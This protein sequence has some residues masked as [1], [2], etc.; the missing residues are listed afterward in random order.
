MM[1][2][3]TQW[4]DDTGAWVLEL[5]PNVF[6][7]LLIAVAGWYLALYAALLVKRSGTR[8][9]W[10]EA[11]VQY[12]ARTVRVVVVVVFA[13]S[14]LKAAGFP[15][16]S[17]LT[18]VGISGVIIG[19]GVRAQIANYFAGVMMLAARPFKKGDLIEFGPPPQI[20]TVT[21]VCMTYTAL[22]S[23]DNV[24]I[25]VPNAVLWRNRIFNFS[26][27]GQRA[28][29]IPITIPYDVNVD[30]V[31]DIALDVLTRHDAV[32]ADPAPSFKVS[33]VTADNVR[34]L[35]VAWSRVESMNVFGDVITQMRGEFAVAGLAVVVPGKDIDL[36]R[37]E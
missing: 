35:L 5:L 14:A 2:V 17:I 10:D 9:K 6:R 25:V 11:L 8:L 36:K 30:W 26:V 31:R 4:V 13:V 1:D 12:L 16:T 3:L 21:E 37:E 20:G 28:I 34:A 18:A 7:G 19:L 23:L 29:R 32:A 24:R 33:D 15:V 27:H 22:E